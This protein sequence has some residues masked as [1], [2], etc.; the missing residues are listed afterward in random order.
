MTCPG[1]RER[2]HGQ[3]EGGD[4]III[5]LQSTE[6]PAYRYTTQKN[7]RNDSSRLELK[8]YHPGLR[9]HVLFRETR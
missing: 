5:H 3:Q 7:R 6:G 2:A 1:R 4:R 8:K 9:K